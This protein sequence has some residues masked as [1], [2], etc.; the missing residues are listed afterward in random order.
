MNELTQAWHEV[1]QTY[2]GFGTVILWALFAGG[3]LGLL[4]Y[5]IRHKGE[6]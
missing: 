5:I 6:E 4:V 1:Q 3:V 2:S